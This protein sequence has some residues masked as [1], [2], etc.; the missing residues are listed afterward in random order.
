MGK[1]PNKLS[2]THRYAR[3][4]AEGHKMDIVY[5][6][7]YPNKFLEEYVD[8][9]GALLESVGEPPIS[10]RR[11]ET[12]GGRAACRRCASHTLFASHNMS[13]SE[14]WFGEDSIG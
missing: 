12:G 2:P 4:M 3:M 14:S 7:P 10:I 11:L 8:K 13:K 9:Y 1:I 5:Y 6:D